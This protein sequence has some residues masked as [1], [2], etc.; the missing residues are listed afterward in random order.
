M[1]LSRRI[2]VT[3]YGAWILIESICFI[4]CGLLE[5]RGHY[6]SHEIS[7]AYF[8]CFVLYV[9]LLGAVVDVPFANVCLHAIMI[10][11]QWLLA[12]F[13]I[14]NIFEV[15]GYVRVWYGL[16]LLLIA[17]CALLDLS[18]AVMAFSR[19]IHDMDL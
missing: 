16:R 9:V 10:A 13:S 8:L 18:P 7:L 5:A 19:K 3:L 17:I 12:S 4:A 2:S 6:V 14:G 15:S 11:H 1:G